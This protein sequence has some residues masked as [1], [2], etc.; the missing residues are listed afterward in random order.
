MNLGIGNI[1][2]GVIAVI[3]SVILVA[4][5]AMPVIKGTSTTNWS[6]SEVAVYGIVGILLIVGLLFT[7]GRAFAIF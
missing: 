6:T 3:I 4:T 7:V 5:V 1:V 2:Y